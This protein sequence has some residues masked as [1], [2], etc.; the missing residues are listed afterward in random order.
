MTTKDL[1]EPHPWFLEDI[2]LRYEL[3]AARFDQALVHYER[4]TAQ[5]SRQLKSDVAAWAADLRTLQRSARTYQYHL[6]ETLTAQLIRSSFTGSAAPST[7]LVQKLRQL[8]QADAANQGGAAPLYPSI[9]TARQML[10]EFDRGPAAWV[11]TH[12]LPHQGERTHGNP[13]HVGLTTA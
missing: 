8:L 4:A 7:A 12:L 3:A 6:Q 10:A 1:L 13:F 2:A 9:A 11:Q 5:L